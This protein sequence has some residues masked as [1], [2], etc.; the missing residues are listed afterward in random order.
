MS[1]ALLIPEERKSRAPVESCASCRY[2][3]GMPLSCHKNPPN[4]IP[5]PSPGGLRLHSFWPPVD[6][7]N[8]C[9]EWQP[10]V[11]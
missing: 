6:K 8:W 3:K 4:V 2:C 1:E 10:T 5:E 9:G 11:Q 7:G